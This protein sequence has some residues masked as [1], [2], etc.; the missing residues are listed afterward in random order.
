MDYAL[1]L[2]LPA[3]NRWFLCSL[4]AFSHRRVVKLRN[5]SLTYTNDF[6]ESALVIQFHEKDASPQADR[7][8]VSH[9]ARPVAARSEHGPA[10]F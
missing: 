7:W 9:P 3:R 5:Y 2:R 6:V 4:N 8:R 10:D 1:K